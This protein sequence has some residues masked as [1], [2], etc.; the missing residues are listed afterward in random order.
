MNL[1]IAVERERV[2]L[3]PFM[4]VAYQEHEPNAQ[5]CV[6]LNESNGSRRRLENIS[7]TSTSRHVA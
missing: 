1:R 4:K 2:A 3:F 5:P 6:T 7:Q